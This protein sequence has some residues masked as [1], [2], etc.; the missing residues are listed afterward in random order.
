MSTDFCEVIK[1][2]RFFEKMKKSVDKNNFIFI[3]TLN[4]TSV[5]FIHYFC[6]LKYHADKRLHEEY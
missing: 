4:N 1:I 2:I 3:L 5:N 6:S